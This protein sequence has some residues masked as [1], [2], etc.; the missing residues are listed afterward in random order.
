MERGPRGRSGVQ[1]FVEGMARGLPDLPRMTPRTIAPERWPE[2]LAS[3]AR[4]HESW[5]VELSGPADAPD[6]HVALRDLRLEP[7]DEQGP[8]VVVEYG[9]RQRPC[10]L[11][12]RGLRRVDVDLV[13]GVEHGLALAGCSATL[14]LQLRTTIA[15]ELVDGLPREC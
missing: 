2:L 5:L 9:E 11:V 3:F 12:L 1:D 10:R 6:N 7:G 14:T 13:D 15:P 4:S 8:R